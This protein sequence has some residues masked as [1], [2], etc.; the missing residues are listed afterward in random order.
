MAILFFRLIAKYIVPHKWLAFVLVGGQIF[1]SGFDA[2]MRMSFKFIIDEAIVPKDYGRLLLILI[3]LGIGAIFLTFSAI[4]GDF[5]WARFGSLVLNEIRRCLFDR[6]QSL[7]MEFFGRR[8]IGDIMNCFLSD[9]TTVENS[10]VIA[11]PSGI[12]GVSNIIFSG[13]LLLSLDWQLATLSCIG[14]TICLIAPQ[15]LMETATKESYHLRQKEGYLASILEENLTSQ[16][17]IKIFG[18]E[19]RMSK[20]F[21]KDLRDLMEVAVRANF[22][23]YLVQRIPT[24]SFIL[25]HLFILTIGAV[26][27]F[28]EWISVGTLVSYQVLFI[29]LSS[30]VSSL[31][32]VIPYLVDGVA[33]MRRI[34]HLLA[35]MPQVRDAPNAVKLSSFDREICFDNVTF[36]YS[37]ERTGVKNISLQINKGE[38]VVFV[39]ASGSGKTT[40][41][42]LL[43][44]FYDPDFG[45]IL[46]DGNDLRHITQ[47]SL[48]SQIGL[49]SQDVILFNC[50]V[51]E[52]IRMGL[53][54]ASD[55]E[56]EN[57]A[58][59]AEIHDFIV[60]LP[61]G[62]DTPVG[63]KGG[64]L[65][66]GQRQRIALARALV[67]NPAILILDE[68]TSAIDPFT[69]AGILATI[70]R[71]AKERTVIAITHRLDR[72]QRANIIFMLHEGRLIAQGR[73]EDLVAQGGI[74]AWFWQN[75]K[76]N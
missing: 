26:M 15:F 64:Q 57:A 65:S 40:L 66:G 42:N 10:L 73:H 27:A 52:N 9:I 4:V 53:L 7:S 38:F 3:W 32:W 68:A 69:E 13:C 28:A 16:S 37:Q 25:L 34:N 23:A 41:I 39:G 21:G 55:E 47:R 29:G 18:L 45:R 24:L 58:K 11:L 22:L 30:A 50:S 43:A 19:S 46:I 75:N 33:A 31:T 76:S 70:D 2:G 67:R 49:V 6:V 5:F 36:N 14:L 72:A 56:I 35:E 60:S 74:Y 61:Q 44:R 48:R 8:A 54:S 71:I 59:A 63:E 20:K 12:L 1:E 62:Y 17:A 51:R